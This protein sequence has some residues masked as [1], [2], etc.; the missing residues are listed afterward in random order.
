MNALSSRSR[1]AGTAFLA[2]GLL[3]GAQ[4]VTGVVGA[5]DATAAET[6]QTFDDVPTSGAANRFTYDVGWGSAGGVGDFYATTVHYATGTATATYT[7]VGT[8]ATIIAGKDAD[9]GTATYAVDGGPATTVSHYSATRQAQSVVF[10]TG[11]LP[12]GTHTITIEAT[13][14]K[15]AASSGVVITLDAATVTGPQLQSLDD[16][17]LTGVNRFGYDLSWGSA[18]GVGD[19]YQGS[20]HYLDDGVVGSGT[21]AF[22]GSQALIIGV[23]DADQG[24]ATYSVDGGAPVEV[25]HYA[26]RRNPQAVLFDTGRLSPGLHTVTIAS[27]GTK[28]PASTKT[29]LALDYAVIDGPVQ[30]PAPPTLFVDLGQSTGPFHGG[31]SGVLYGLY[32]EG[33]PSNNL[34]DGINLRTV[35]TKAQ[36]G[37]QH[38]G[39]DALEV[40]GPLA[41]SS[42]GDVYIYMT[43][44]YR[45]FPYQWPGDTP[46]ARLAD[47]MAK[48]EAQV[49]QVLELPEEYQDNIVFVP[50]NEPE[51]NM[52]GTGTWSYNGIS[53]L[54]DPSHFYA[55]W[56]EAHGLIRGLMPD[57]RIAGPNTSILFDQDRDF[58]RHT[59]AEGTVPDV[60]T[61]HELSDPAS[62]RRNVAKYR[63]WETAD[64]AGTPYAGTHLPININEYAYNYHT[65]V[66]GQM[67]QWI[68]AIEDNKVDADIAYWNID[69]NLSDSAVQANR[70]NGQWWLLNAYSQMTGETVKVSPPSPNV[71]YTLQ[72]VATLDSATTQAR[73]IIGGS[74]GTADV[75]FQRVP[76]AFGQTAHVFVQEI[77]WT[78]TIGDSAPPK[79]IADLDVAVIGGEVKL[80]FGATLPALKESSAYQVI[81]TPGAADTTP[82]PK[83]TAWEATYEAEAAAYTGSP[84]YAN[85]PEG[86]PSNVSG[87]FTSG[88]RNV[89]GF[90]TGSTLKLD[91][92]V[93]APQDGTY[94]LS[95]F[96]NSLNTFAAVREQGPTNV[97]LTVDGAA[98]QELFL[99]LGYKWVVWDHTDTTVDLTAGPHTISLSARSLDGSGATLGDAIVDKIDLSLR[100]PEAAATIYEAEYATLSGGTLDYGRDGASGSGAVALGADGSATFWVYSADDAW[101]DLAVEATGGGTLTVNGLSAGAV[102][103]PTAVTAFLS[104]GVNKV[105]VGGSA[106]GVTVDR[107]AVHP[108]SAASQQT[109][110][111]AEDAEVAGTAGVADYSLARGGQGVTGIGGAPGNDNT[112]TFTVDAKADGVQAV[113]I[114][115]TNEEQIAATHYNPD[116]VA[117]HADIS[118]NGAAPVRVTFPHSFHKNNFWELTVPVELTAGEN[119]IELR[120]EELTNVDG[121]TYASDLYPDVTLRS[122]YAPNVDAIAI[123]PFLADTTPPTASIA[124]EPAEPDGQNGWYTTAAQISVLGTDDSG[125]ASLEYSLDDG[126]TWEFF[127][128]PFTVADGART[129]LARVTDVYGNAATAS[130]ELQQDTVAPVVTLIGGP[131]GT[132]FFDEVPAVPTCSAADATSGVDGCTVTGYSSA[133]GEHTLVAAATDRAGL[134]GESTR[135]YTVAGYTTKG[136]YRPVDM[137]AIN[138]VRARSTVPLKF[139]VFRGA[140]EQIDPAVVQSITFARVPRTAGQPVDEIETLAAGGRALR[141]DT[142]CGQFIYNWKTPTAKGDYRVTVTLR[143]GSTIEALFRLR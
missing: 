91:F 119:T 127:T 28:N 140:V 15:E 126:A 62:I 79:V 14:T 9:Q 138:T 123:T 37:P 35:S 85:G 95:V 30:P 39:A 131:S 70:G 93:D 108:S 94:D 134:R 5:P 33:L 100:N 139:E 97:F 117:R 54:N 92:A 86:S 130:Q 27:T 29:I 113:T 104:G 48:M 107:V 46:E 20:V 141:Y 10:E 89:G 36:D 58:L 19:L 142:R 17:T 88:S 78:G 116:I 69:G 66:P 55:A 115:Y 41:D 122:R 25:D 101:A 67:I 81:L 56:D 96:A 118:I 38:P 112:L 31:A 63:S 136:F 1:R 4:A 21:F 99:T 23:K 6:V 24:I 121:V 133:V 42:D 111:E 125:V 90:L 74:S 65:S 64:F 103:G 2:V 76:A 60:F 40:V 135:P 59:I 87:F 80:A 51:G 8:S 32:G 18:G 47:Y 71:S 137:D 72:G 75:L 34:I 83:T 26:S 13:G 68:S 57:A 129:V 128:E 120:S 11:A 16:N 53:W 52:F 49:R 124:V 22:E 45:G 3:V 77:P 43:D 132:V 114:R 106:A 105:V 50:F 44:I 102:D 109:W 98:E 84:Y 82:Q 143:D 12:L 73:A 61:W 7:F 110:Y